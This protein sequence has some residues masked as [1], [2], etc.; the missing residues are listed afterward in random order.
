MMEHASPIGFAVKHE[1]EMTEQQDERKHV[2][3]AQRLHIHTHAHT[4][5]IN[6]NIKSY[7]SQHKTPRK[8]LN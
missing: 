4:Q 7:F 2:L 5:K 3:I 6:F 1:T 8:K